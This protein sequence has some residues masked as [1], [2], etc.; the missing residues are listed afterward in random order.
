MRKLFLVFPLLFAPTI[1]LGQETQTVSPILLT[2][3][4]AQLIAEVI[5]TKSQ[6]PSFNAE[7]ER[8]LRLA[9]STR[10]WANYRYMS[11]SN[12]DI[13]IKI[14]EDQTLVG[15]ETISLT[16]FNPEN[17]QKL[18]SETRDLVDLSNDVPRLVAHFL[19]TVVQ[20]KEQVK[21]RQKE[22]ERQARLRGEIMSK[23]ICPSVELYANRAE[24]RRVRKILYKDDAVGVM[25]SA[26]NEFVVK[27]GND[28]GYVNAD[29]LETTGASRTHEEIAHELNKPK[30]SVNN[31]TPV[32]GTEIEKPRGSGLY[33]SSRPQGAAV[34][35]NGVK[36][37]GKTPLTMPLAPGQY[38]LVLRLPGYEAYVAAI[39]VKETTQTQ[40]EVDLKESTVP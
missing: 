37:S 1:V 39:Q 10:L 21:Q 38:N 4:T 35:V 25:M 16:V 9:S 12:A 34:F 31:K 28:V 3:K 2:T 33:V 19:A 6:K 32:S 14:Q 8:I 13:I 11:G 5:G 30:A 15:S 29:C 22:E 36:Q 7:M 27:S 20:Q 26:G 40:V 24:T 18:Y 23:I 17:N